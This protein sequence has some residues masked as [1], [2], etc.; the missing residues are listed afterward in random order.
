MRRERRGRERSTSYFIYYESH[1]Y[2]FPPL[3]IENIN[4]AFVFIRG[5]F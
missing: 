3:A 4:Q 1:F 2:A 5:R